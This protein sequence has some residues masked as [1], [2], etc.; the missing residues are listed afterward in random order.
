VYPS[1]KTLES[2][3]HGQIISNDDDVK[4]MIKTNV[5]VDRI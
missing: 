4:E 1:T 5:N 2:N 3:I